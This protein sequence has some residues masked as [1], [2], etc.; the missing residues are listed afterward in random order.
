MSFTSDATSSSTDGNVSLHDF[1]WGMQHTSTQSPSYTVQF[2]D[3]LSNPLAAA[4]F[5]TATMVFCSL[6]KTMFMFH[7]KGHALMIVILS[8]FIY[9]FGVTSSPPSTSDVSGRNLS[10]SEAVLLNACL[11]LELEVTTGLHQ[12]SSYTLANRCYSITFE[13]DTIQYN[14]WHFRPTK[15]IWENAT[16]IWA[17]KDSVTRYRACT[18]A[19]L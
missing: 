11:K 10:E 8:I 4:C 18:A 1:L 9:S 5:K 6:L 3:I 2:S 14:E 19:G 13:C 7:K 12:N 16:E 15:L 17:K